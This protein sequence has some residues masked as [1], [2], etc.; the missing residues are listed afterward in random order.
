MPSREC[1]ALL[2]DFGNV[3]AA[4]VEGGV[5]PTLLAG[6]MSR[7]FRELH[8]AVEKRRVAGDFGFL[9]LPC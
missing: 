6:D 2:F 8:A 4:R 1:Q 3:M 9:D 7:T 5:D